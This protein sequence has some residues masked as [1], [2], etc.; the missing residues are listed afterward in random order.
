MKNA[1]NHA[2]DKSTAAPSGAWGLG[3]SPAHFLVGGRRGHA[4]FLFPVCVL[5]GLCLEE[6]AALATGPVQTCQCHRQEKQGT[7]AA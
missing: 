3:N 5:G 2:W 1:A 6:A 4:E 7:K